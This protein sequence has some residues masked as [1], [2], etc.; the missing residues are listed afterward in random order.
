MCEYRLR[1]KNGDLELEYVDEYCWFIELQTERIFDLL[2]QL[3]PDAEEGTQP[4]RFSC[5]GNLY[6]MVLRR[7][8]LAVELSTDS[9]TDFMQR[10]MNLWLQSVIARKPFNLLANGV[11]D[12]TTSSSAPDADTTSERD[13]SQEDSSGGGL[14]PQLEALAFH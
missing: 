1:V 5:T 14:A 12:R 2:H 4:V 11:V 3:P 13:T 7:G 10:Q 9:D 6:K 8:T